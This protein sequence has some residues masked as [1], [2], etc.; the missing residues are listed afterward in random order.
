[1]C[2]RK[3]FSM[4]GVNWIPPLP[5]P[6]TF[7]HGSV[8]LLSDIDHTGIKETLSLMVRLVPTKCLSCGLTNIS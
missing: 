4:L 1:M 5:P 2:P 3:Y 6:L 7:F 8:T